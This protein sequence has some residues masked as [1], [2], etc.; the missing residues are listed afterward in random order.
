MFFKTILRVADLIIEFNTDYYQL[1]AM[2][3]PWIVENVIPDFS[4]SATDEMI[5]KQRREYGESC[6]KNGYFESL[7]AYRE[8]AENLHLYDAFLLHSASFE[9]DG[10]GIAFAARSGTGKT[11]H[12]LYWKELLG[13]RMTYIN[14]DKPIVRFIN[15]VPYIYGTPFQ[16]KEHFGDNVSAVFKHICFI[17]RG[18]NNETIKINKKDAFSRIVNQVFMP[19]SVE[20]RIKTLQLID[21]ILSKCD[22]WLIKCNLDNTSAEVAYN[23]IFNR[24][25]LGENK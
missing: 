6:N 5:E 19:N 17:E 14:G 3:R 4:I 25:C 16:G 15:D 8:L 12:M 1:T 9:V 13:E 22:L 7:C 2:S 24:N 10:C 21:K 20:G 23:C 18:L 11:T